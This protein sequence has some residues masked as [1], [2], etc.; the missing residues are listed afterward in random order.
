MVWILFLIK[1]R[2]FE[3]FKFECFCCAIFL[4][5]IRMSFFY[6]VT[7]LNNNSNFLSTFRM[8]CIKYLSQQEN[9]FILKWILWR[10]VVVKFYQKFFFQGN[11]LELDI[12]SFT[13][14]IDEKFQLIILVDKTVF[15]LRAS[16]FFVQSITTIFHNYYSLLRLM[17]SVIENI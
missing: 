2:T 12:F 14:K 3:S 17:C 13:L 9:I 11:F 10:K 6:Y 4:K 8:L 15:I 1:R 7:F 16:S 5:T